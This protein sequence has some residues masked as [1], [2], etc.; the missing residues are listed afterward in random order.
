MRLGFNTNG[1]QSHRL[2]DALRLLA[3]HGFEWVA[4]TP[5]VGHLDPLRCTPR[6][7]DAVAA[8]LAELSLGVTIETGAR[9]VLDPSRKHEPTLMTADPV[10]VARRI[11]YYARCA[12]LGA[13]LGARVVSF[14]AGVDRAPGP[15]SAERLTDGVR[16]AADA[17]RAAGLDPALEP[18]PGMAV[19]DLAG[20]DRLCAALGGSAPALCLDVG[21][22]FVTE[23]A[24][25]VAL[26]RQ[27]AARCA[28]VHLEDVRRGV[29][30]HLEPGAGEVP[31]PAVLDA[32]HDG[33][34]AGP[35]CF[36][37]SRSSHRA[38]DAVAACR[39]VWDAWRGAR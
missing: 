14:W 24:D 33:G 25:P 12:A 3:D 22:L 21:H 9:F 13:A 36:E 11:D 27:R 28:Q 5:D 26:C 29:H 6:E 38:P 8:R 16:R 15:R 32:L 1:L 7:I 23:R 39:A 19:E 2:D 18:E 31:F 34:Y 17:I 35:V 37:L 10:G 4:L 20:F 30:E